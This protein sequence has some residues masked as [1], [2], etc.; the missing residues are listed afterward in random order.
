MISAGPAGLQATNYSPRFTLSA[1]SGTFPPTILAGISSIGTSTDG[2]AASNSN[3][4]ENAGAGGAAGTAVGDSSGPYATPYNQQTGPTKYAP[5][6]KRPGTKITAVSARM[7]NPTSFAT[8]AS[9]YMAAP[10]VQ[11]TLTQS[12]TGS[13][14]SRENAVCYV[15][16]FAFFRLLALALALTRSPLFGRFRATTLL[17]HDCFWF[18]F[19]LR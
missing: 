15:F 6:A 5:M 11:T 19:F 14:V 13:V 10:K 7:Q 4:N 1:M 12:V 17:L 16:F 9:A 18:L 3:S 2:P 8:L